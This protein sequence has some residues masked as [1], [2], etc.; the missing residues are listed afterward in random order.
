MTNA[1]FVPIRAI[2]FSLVYDGE[3]TPPDNTETET[4]TPPTENQETKDKKKSK[5]QF[6]PEQQAYV[7]S[8][9]AE[10]KRR[11]RQSADALVTQLE[12]Q[13]N[14]TTTTA[15]EKEALQARIDEIKSQYATKEELHKKDT[16]KKIKEANNARL[17]AEKEAE[18][19]KALF[20]EHKITNEIL[21]A[22]SQYKAYNP[23][24]LVRLLRPDTRLVEVLDAD[25]KPVPGQWDVRINLNAKDKSGNPVTLDLAV[26]EA[27]KQMTEMPDIYGNLFN[28]GA[29]GGLGSGNVQGKSGSGEPPKD[30]AGY[31]EW[32]KNQKAK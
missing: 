1:Y 14:L 27:V 10:E 4:E 18:H 12:T 13:K 5:V 25:S 16:D 23:Q 8:L 28:S 2:P 9:V 20:T 6:T 19:W 7:N 22:G 26:T 29:T 11:G 30:T 15:A 32:R 21:S 24:Q 3:E 17:K 31:M